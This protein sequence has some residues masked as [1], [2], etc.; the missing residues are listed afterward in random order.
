MLGSIRNTTLAFATVLMVVLPIISISDVS[1]SMDTDLNDDEE[2][3]AYADYLTVGIF[4]NESCTE[5]PSS[6][7]T[8]DIQYL[9]LANDTKTLSTSNISASPLYFKIDGSNHSWS[10]AN[11]YF[12]V[13]A[14]F[15]CYF[16]E[17]PVSSAQMTVSFGNEL[18]LKANS[19]QEDGI[20]NLAPGVYPLSFSVS[21][22]SVQMNSNPSDIDIRI[23]IIVTD[24]NTGTF[25]GSSVTTISVASTV[26]IVDT[27]TADI[28]IEAVNSE[29]PYVSGNTNTH[30]IQ[31]S[32]SESTPDGN[33]TVYSIEIKA[34]NQQGVADGQ[35]HVTLDV[36]IPTGERFCVRCSGNRAT[37]TTNLFWLTITIDGV[38]KVAG[39]GDKNGTYYQ[40]WTNTVFNSSKN[41]FSP[42]QCYSKTYN[43]DQ[44]IYRANDKDYWMTGN[45]SVSLHLAGKGG[46][47]IPNDIKL[48]IIFWPHN[49]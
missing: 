15:S 1:G 45:S 48:E 11:E 24:G 40:P 13:S 42:Q 31:D 46:E 7:L 14:T 30:V 22:A 41:V 12:I 26:P 9:S 34:K 32:T 37:N 43:S 18:S 49:G 6:I 21:N 47:T 2:V 3:I 39:I 16:D 44:Y 25:I 5:I 29:N 8:N 20:L 27:E 36:I 33:T 10:T 38:S 4:S 35:G 19:E 23:S 28:S 17:T